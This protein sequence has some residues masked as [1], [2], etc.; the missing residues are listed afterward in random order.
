MG[1][2]VVGESVACLQPSSQHIPVRVCVG[3]TGGGGLSGTFRGEREKIR[4]LFMVAG[5]GRGGGEV[6]AF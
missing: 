3:V 1:G 6:N 5:G 4:G 2:T